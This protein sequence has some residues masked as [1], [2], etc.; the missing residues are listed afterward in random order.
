VTG[1]GF[2]LFLWEQSENVIYPDLVTQPSPNP[3]IITG[4]DLDEVLLF[5]AALKELAICCLRHRDM[6]VE[7]STGYHDVFGSNLLSKVKAPC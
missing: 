5:G 2:R 3:G 6:S 4:Q 7:A 1:S